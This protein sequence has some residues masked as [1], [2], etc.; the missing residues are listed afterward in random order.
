MS[1]PSR[2]LKLLLPRLLEEP[3]LIDGP[4]PSLAVRSVRTRK[5]PLLDGGRVDSGNVS[6]LQG[7]QGYRSK[8]ARVL[9]ALLTVCLPCCSLRCCR[10][11]S[12]RARRPWASGCPACWVLWLGRQWGV[13]AWAQAD[14]HPCPCGPCR[15]GHH[16]EGAAV[17]AARPGGPAR[18]SWGSARRLCC[19]GEEPAE[20]SSPPAR[21]QI[22]CVCAKRGPRCQ[23]GQRC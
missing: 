15:G 16:A 5:V 17:A 4:G 14:A 23:P 1:R 22:G 13:G 20:P 10:R 12:S 21:R 9:R 3:P 7:K 19:P 6:F 8:W 18:S 2:S 11:S